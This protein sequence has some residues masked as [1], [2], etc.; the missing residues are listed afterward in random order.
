MKRDLP[1]SPTSSQSP[2]RQSRRNK[3]GK[4][5]HNTDHAE[6][7]APSAESASALAKEGVAAAMDVAKTNG[8]ANGTTTNSNGHASSSIDNDN[9]AN[10]FHYPKAVDPK[11]PYEILQQYHSKPTKLRIACIGAGASGLC[12]AYKMVSLRSPPL[13]TSFARWWRCARGW[14]LRLLIVDVGEANGPRKLGAHFVREEPRLWR[15]L[16]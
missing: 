5:H 2:Q 8:R 7:M 12:L 16:G 15:H 4:T 1:S 6:A 10:T 3:V 14:N 11:A 9:G 13:T